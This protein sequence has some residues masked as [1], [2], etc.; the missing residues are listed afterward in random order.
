MKFT[1]EPDE[2]D[3]LQGIVEES[4]EHLNGIEE[5]ILKLEMEFSPDLLDSVFRALHSVKGVSSFVDFVPLKETAHALESFMT[6]MRK[7]LFTATSEITDLMLRGVDILNLLVGQLR[8]RVGELENDPPRE[9]FSIDINEFG[10]EAFVAEAEGLRQQINTG[11]TEIKEIKNAAVKPSGDPPGQLDQAVFFNQMRADFMEETAEHLEA[12]EQACVN[13]EKRPSDPEILNLILRGFHSIKGGAGVIASMQES[14]DNSHPVQLIKR[15]THAVETLLQGH[16]NQSRP[17]TPEGV[18]LI[19]AAVD[20]TGMLVNLLKH[21]QEA[22]PDFE[23]FIA[24]VEAMQVSAPVTEQR[25]LKTIAGGILPQQLEA[26]LNIS[27]QAMDSIESIITSAQINTPI[28]G[29][30]M[31]QYIR[32]LHNVASTARYLNY[33]EVIQEVEKSIV[34]LETIVPE[35]DVLS[36]DV[37]KLLENTYERLKQLLEAR[38]ESIRSMIEQI[39]PD[40][41]QKR[42]GEILVDEHKVTPEQVQWALGKQHKLGTILVS[43]GIVKE[44]EMEMA[45]AKQAI[46]QQKVQEKEQSN[47]PEIGQSIRVSQEKLDRLMNMIGELLI[48]KNQVFHL[49]SRIGIDYQLPALSR[50]V[51]NVAADLGRISDE[52]QDAIMSARMIPLRVLFQRYP[53]TVRDTSR[54]AAKQVELIIEGEDIE[55]DKTVI[56]AIND[57]LVHMLRNA[58][59]HAI[60]LPEV[61]QEMGK[62][63]TGSVKLK[64]FYQGNYAVI[65]VADDGKGLNPPELKLKALKKGLITSSQIESMSDD[66]A[67]QLIFAPGFSTRDEVSELSGRGVGM[68]VVKNNIEGVGGTIGVVSAVNAGTTFTLKIP[69]S[70]SIIRGLMV[71]SSGQQFII[72]LDCIEETVKLPRERLRIYKQNM[73]ADIRGE[74]LPLIQLNKILGIAAPQDSWAAAA[75]VPVVVIAV[76]GLKFGL[77]IDSFQKEQEFVVKALAEELANLKMYAGATIMGDGSVVLI[78]N[79]VQLLYMQNAAGNRGDI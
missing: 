57:P 45:L 7:G 73:M 62:P 12:I 42:I 64:A 51:R 30:R 50:E 27:S 39:P 75:M 34:Q 61:R 6:D 49:A 72:P 53:R 43:E 9:A 69:L 36:Q 8:D 35:K 38:A 15:L 20:R 48:S 44:E 58:V 13:L 55:L 25:A 67:Y 79:P 65:E 10:F 19:L 18:D 33:E 68:D 70:M 22:D 14:D 17:I 2:L 78:L 47:V 1:F 29:K 40:Y 11:G 41:G 28:N 52:L 32:A 56:E 74:I 71:T 77:I 31:K 54:K 60:E 37:L 26:F 3:I 4:T 24:R 21:N 46:A 66:E 59:D 16:R 23:A 63:V 76:D 5:G